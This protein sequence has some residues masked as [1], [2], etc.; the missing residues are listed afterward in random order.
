MDILGSEI[1]REG[2]QVQSKEWKWFPRSL[3]AIASVGTFFSDACL[4]GQLANWIIDQ[5]FETELGRGNG[6]DWY[7]VRKKEVFRSKF[8]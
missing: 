7:E 2:R 5:I 4:I 8:T 3:G 6:L 1:S